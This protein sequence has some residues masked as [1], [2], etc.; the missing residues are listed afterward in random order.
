M[1][2]KCQDCARRWPDDEPTRIALLRHNGSDWV[3]LDLSLRGTN[4]RGGHGLAPQALP[5][6]VRRD[7]S[8]VPKTGLL[9]CRRA[10]P[11]RRLPVGPDRLV[12]LA[13][14]AAADGKSYF[15]V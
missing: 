4:G 9:R 15:L 6:R 8:V 13:W 1:V 12:E 5:R 3:V 11:P 7:G 10:R 2:A 14:V